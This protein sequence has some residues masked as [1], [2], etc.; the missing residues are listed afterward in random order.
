MLLQEAERIGQLLNSMDSKSIDPVLNIGS[1]TL[2]FRE[3]VP[4]MD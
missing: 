3:K 1:S 4:A 2:E